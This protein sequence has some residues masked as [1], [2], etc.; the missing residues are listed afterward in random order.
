MIDIDLVRRE[1]ALIAQV[2][3]AKG[4]DVDV[5]ALLS[6][7]SQL[8]SVTTEIDNL[9]HQL[10]QAS[11]AVQRAEDRGAAVAEARAMGTRISELEEEQRRLRAEFDGQMALLPNILAPEVPIGSSD[12]DDVEVRRW[13]SQPVFDFPAKDHIELMADLDMVDFEAPRRFAGARSYALTGWGALLEIAVMRYALDTVVAR[14]FTPVVTPTAVRESAMFGT[15]FFPVGREDAYHIEADDLFLAGTSEVSLV[16]LYG[17]S[18]LDA[19]RLPIRM[20][21]W[22]TCYRREAGSAGRDT[23]GLYRVHQFQKVEQVVICEADLDVSE[24]EHYMLLENA[25]QIL[26]GLE[27]PYRVAVACSG[28]TGQGQY[29]KHEVETW[30]PSRGRYSETHSC[31]TLLDFQA[32]RSR[33]RYRTEDGSRQFVHTLNNTAVASPR[34][35]IPL[36]ENHQQPDGSIR[37]PAALQPYLFGTEAIDKPLNS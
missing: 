34:I 4:M 23:R 31:S 11:K 16:S 28:E 6:F 10:K 37:V 14:G 24:R 15:G 29:R 5:D 19:E 13:G 32:R 18:I 17:D 20:A 27:L 33:I 12:E 21:G 35:L 7:D 1:P 9:R 25:E 8:R 36:L 3:K 22:S 26:R 2:A 30:M